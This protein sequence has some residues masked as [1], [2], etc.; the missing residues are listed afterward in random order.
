ML[1]RSKAFSWGCFAPQVRVLLG[2][3][4]HQE[5][6][7][8]GIYQLFFNYFD[9]II[10][11]V[12]T[13]SWVCNQL[14]RKAYI[15]LLTCESTIKAWRIESN[16][17]WNEQTCFNKCEHTY[18]SVR[19]DSIYDTAIFLSYL[20]KSINFMN[21]VFN[22]RIFSHWSFSFPNHA[23]PMSKLKSDWLNFKKE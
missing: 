10:S 13:A 9:V 12:A 14:K 15:P 18:N 7:V 1:V 5:N 22:D 4:T 3:K 19:R 8:Y 23:S 6:K 2:L 20:K 17:K 11:D 21:T 16:R